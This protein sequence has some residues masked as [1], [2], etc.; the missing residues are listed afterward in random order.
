MPIYLVI[1][2]IGRGKKGE[3]TLSK[4]NASLAEIQSDILTQMIS[5]EI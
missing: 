5:K 4:G 3:S 2:M 1:F